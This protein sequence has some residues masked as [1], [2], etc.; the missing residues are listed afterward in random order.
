MWEHQSRP[1]WLQFHNSFNPTACG[2][3]CK[4]RCGSSYPASPP[5]L[6]LALASTLRGQGAAL[7]ETT[8]SF[9]FGWVRFPFLLGSRCACGSTGVGTD[10]EVAKRSRG[11][12]GKQNGPDF[13]ELC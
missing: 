7:L 11:W 9:C 1:L 4:G 8:L 2:G 5:F 3:C 13:A 6:L 10:E 12:V